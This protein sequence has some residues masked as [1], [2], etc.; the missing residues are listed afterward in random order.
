MTAGPEPPDL[1]PSYT[2]ERRVTVDLDDARPFDAARAHYRLRDAG[3]HEIESRVSSGGEG[4]HV[5]AWFDADKLDAAAV[6]TLRLLAGD[7]PRRT[8]MDRTHAD[9]PQ[10][11]LFTRK[12]DDEAGDWHTDPWDAVDDF[13]RRSCR[14]DTDRFD[15]DK[16][17]WPRD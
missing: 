1:P 12:G 11:V 16:G 6:E 9:K 14:F 15:F 17:G 10:Q 3:A 4:F 7:H 13:L 8:M 2:G 5:R